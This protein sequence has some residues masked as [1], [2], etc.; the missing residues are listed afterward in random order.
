MDCAEPDTLEQILRIATQP[1][2]MTWIYEE[3]KK[4][5]RQLTFEE[6]P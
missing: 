5:R 1:H 4:N 3:Q 6:S 2:E